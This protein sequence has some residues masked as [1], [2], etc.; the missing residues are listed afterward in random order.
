[1]SKIFQA[2]GS[3]G[4][5]TYSVEWKRG[6]L[7]LTPS[8]GKAK[9]TLIPG[10]VDIHFHGAFGIDFMSAS[11]DQMVTLLDKLDAVGYDRVLLT[12]VTAPMTDVLAA[13]NNVPEHPL[14]GGFH[15]EGPFISPKYPGAQPQNHI[16]SAEGAWESWAPVWAN[17]QIKIVTMAPEIPGAIPLAKKLKEL[18]V[19]VSMGHTNATVE[20]CL[21][22][23]GLFK[24]VTHTYNAMRGL[25]H[26]EVGA[27]GFAL[28]TPITCELLFD[29]YHVSTEAAQILMIARRVTNVVGISDSTMASGLPNGSRIKM[30]GQKCVVANGTVKIEGT[31][32]LA[33]SAV[34]LDMVFGNL[35]EQF[36]LATA[37]R[38]CC[39][40]PAKALKIKHQTWLELDDNLQIVNRY[41]A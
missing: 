1:M 17:K 34:T 31:D 5:G 11:T 16:R 35:W 20:E 4:L 15:I 29:G 30:W 9:S 10:F 32:T 3:K 38:L 37:I 7:R 28:S 19:I 39:I 27:L 6:K 40:N 26:R 21:E 36:D 33:G 8:T 22:T 24:H 13:M 12:S 23:I 18:G 14:F 25:H 41:N 2:F